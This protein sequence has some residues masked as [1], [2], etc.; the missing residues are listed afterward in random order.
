MPVFTN[1]IAHHIK[2]R[3]LFQIRQPFIFFSK[4]LLLLLFVNT[5]TEHNSAGTDTGVVSL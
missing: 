2:V 5:F 4:E 3:S 1:D